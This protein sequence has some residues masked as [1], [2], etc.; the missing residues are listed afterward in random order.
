MAATT[1]FPEFLFRSTIMISL[2]TSDLLHFNQ[3]GSIP[4]KN[5]FVIR[6][7]LFDPRL[8]IR[9]KLYGSLTVTCYNVLLLLQDN[10][11]MIANTFLLYTD[12]ILLNNYLVLTLTVEKKIELQ[13]I[14]QIVQGTG[15]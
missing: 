12:Y 15:I 14:C 13:F 6:A 2:V 1:I 10:Q 7:V 9:R 5:I 3:R 4:Y 11:V 8:K